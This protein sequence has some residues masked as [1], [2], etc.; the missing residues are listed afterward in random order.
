MKD[1]H[2]QP[3]RREVEIDRCYFLASKAPP[4]PL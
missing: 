3:E 1:L 4:P 2:A